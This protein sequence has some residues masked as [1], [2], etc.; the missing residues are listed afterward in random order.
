MKCWIWRNRQAGAHLRIFWNANAPISGLPV[1]KKPE[2]S[3]PSNIKRIFTMSM[4]ESIQ[5]GRENKPPRIMIYGSE[6]VGKS[7]FGA[8]APNAIFIQTEDGLGEINCRKFPLANSISEVIAE[9]TALRDEPHDFQTV[10]I[11][12]ADWLER[13][14]F[15]EVCREFGVRS[16]EKADGGYGKGYTHALTHW[17]KVINLLQELRD[18]RGM[19]VIIVA[20]A[21]VERFEDPENA[22][23]DRYTPRLHKHAASLI[24]EWVDAV[25]FANKKFRVAKDGNDRAV[26]TPIGADGGERIIRT[27]GSPAC[28]AKNRFGLP[29]EI[30]L[31]WAAFI[32]AYQKAQE[33]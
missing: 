33:A 24:A 23:Y 15:D 21:K 27:V 16:I 9:L 2:S 4:L 3:T 31:S 6:G 22:A 14:I 28:I 1:T 20:H 5:S 12:S 10:V 19:M 25:L 32:T 11:D 29:S 8:S 30:P 7:T 26:A 13:L 18:K 17:R